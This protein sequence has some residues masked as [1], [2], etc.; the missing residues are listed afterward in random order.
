MTRPVVYIRKPYFN[1]TVGNKLIIECRVQSCSKTSLKWYFNNTHLVAGEGV[2][3][4]DVSRQR[5]AFSRLTIYDAN[6]TNHSGVYICEANDNVRTTRSAPVIP[7]KFNYIYPSLRACVQQVLLLTDFSNVTLGVSNVTFGVSGSRR[8]RGARHANYF[9]VSSRASVAT[10]KTISKCL[11]LL[12][13]MKIQSWLNYLPQ[14]YCWEDWLDSSLFQT[15][16]TSTKL[17]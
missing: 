12:Q 4:T 14:Q 7:G 10:D 16:S 3:I 13:S 11:V 17:Q 6:P 5:T 1:F 15:P 2:S 9:S 8:E